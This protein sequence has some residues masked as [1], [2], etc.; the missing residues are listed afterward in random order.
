MT[1]FLSEG[2]VGTH[3]TICSPLLPSTEGVPFLSVTIGKQTPTSVE[4]ILWYF[5]VIHDTLDPWATGVSDL[6]DMTP[7]RRWKAMDKEF[8][9]EQK[10]KLDKWKNKIQEFCCGSPSCM[11]EGTVAET[12]N[13]STVFYCDDCY[14]KKTV[15]DILNSY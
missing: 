11:N 15:D 13:G 14:A 2:P 7:A 10:R 3:Q 6:K 5:G 8:C 9:E 1:Y 4:G 12:F